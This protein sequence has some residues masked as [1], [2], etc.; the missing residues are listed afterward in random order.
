MTVERLPVACP[1]CGAVE[2]DLAPE[3]AKLST[4]ALLALH[5]SELRAGHVRGWLASWRLKQWDAAGELAARVIH[6]A[7]LKALL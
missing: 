6:R 3:Q 2:V 7:A 5:L 4:W 1:V